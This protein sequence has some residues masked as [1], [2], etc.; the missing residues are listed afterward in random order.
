MKSLFG[1]ERAPW[2]DR[3]VGMGQFQSGYGGE[4]FTYGENSGLYQN[5]QA[6]R[7]ES[8]E[9]SRQAQDQCE[10]NGTCPSRNGP[11]AT[12]PMNRMPSSIPGAGGA[13]NT[14]MRGYGGGGGGGMAP[15]DS[16]SFPGAGGG[17]MIAGRIPLSGG[18]G[19]RVFG[20]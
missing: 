10:A 11:V 8:D 15:T 4:S 13:I 16:G 6:A 17:A 19:R 3:Q 18:L 7:G 9:A 14:P 12:Y 5:Q 2:G 20:G 1:N